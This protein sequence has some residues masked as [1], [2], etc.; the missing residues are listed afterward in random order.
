MSEQPDSHGKVMFADHCEH[1]AESLPSALASAVG[2][3]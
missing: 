2:E 1:D 3:A